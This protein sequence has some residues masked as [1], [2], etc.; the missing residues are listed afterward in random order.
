MTFRLA[1]LMANLGLAVVCSLFSYVETRAVELTRNG[2]RYHVDVP[3]PGGARFHSAGVDRKAQVNGV[4]VNLRLIQDSYADCDALVQE[5][6]VSMAKRGYASDDESAVLTKRECQLH[7]WSNETDEHIISH[8]IWMDIC[9]C[10]AAV[11]ISYPYRLEDRYETVSGPITL[12]L[13][14]ASSSKAQSPEHRARGRVKWGL[15]RGNRDLSEEGVFGLD[16]VCAAHRQ[17]PH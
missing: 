10:Y 12:A 15:D 3:L 1:R 16:G 6:R 9:M 17:R 7:Q 14:R 2:T 13:R 4:T 11:H 5:R 8:Y